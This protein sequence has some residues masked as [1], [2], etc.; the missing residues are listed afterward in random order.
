MFGETAMLDGS[1][2]TAVAIADL[3]AVVHRLDKSAFEALSAANPNLGQRLALNM[4]V[5]LAERL[6]DASMAW[7]ASAG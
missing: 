1:G 4:A 2:R 6:R 5:H 3:P 7:R